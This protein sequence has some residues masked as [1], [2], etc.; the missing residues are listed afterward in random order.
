MH[1]KDELF[2]LKIINEITE[3]GHKLWAQKW[4]ERVVRWCLIAVGVA[5]WGALINLIIKR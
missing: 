2:R 1:D 4:V 5:F 3:S